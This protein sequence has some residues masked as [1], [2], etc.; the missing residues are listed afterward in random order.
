MSVPTAYTVCFWKF[1]KPIDKEL[2]SKTLTFVAAP[3]QLLRNIS[4]VLCA[5]SVTVLVPCESLSKAPSRKTLPLGRLLR[6]FL[7][8]ALSPFLFYRFRC[9]CFTT[10]VDWST[11]CPSVLWYCLWEGQTKMLKYS[12]SLFFSPSYL[13]AEECFYSCYQKGRMSTRTLVKYYY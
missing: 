2:N 8:I 12:L 3:C 4:Y 1:R 11:S 6:R 5:Y 9:L 13:L 10:Y 7:S